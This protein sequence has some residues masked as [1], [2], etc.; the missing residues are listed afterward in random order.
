M[1]WYCF[2]PCHYTCKVRLE[3]ELAI[4]VLSSFYKLCEMWVDWELFKSLSCNVYSKSNNNCSYPQLS[5]QNGFFLLLSAVQSTFVYLWGHVS[6]Q[7]RNVTPASTVM[8]TICLRGNLRNPKCS[9]PVLAVQ[10]SFLCTAW[11][12]SQ[13]PVSA[14]AAL[15][16]CSLGYQ[17]VPMLHTVKRQP[18]WTQDSL[19]L[20]KKTCHQVQEGS[21]C[22]LYAQ[23]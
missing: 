2:T 15:W 21:I 1:E 8:K 20:C 22:S 12:A 4:F 13:T 23:P 14:Q 17:N 19:N 5:A 6:W 3:H 11:E 16:L 18:P 9:D 7:N 10:L